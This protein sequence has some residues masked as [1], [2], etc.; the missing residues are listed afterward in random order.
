MK[1]VRYDYNM[2]VHT[3]YT[4][5]NTMDANISSQDFNKW[6]TKLWMKQGVFF[7]GML[8]SESGKRMNL[9]VETWNQIVWLEPVLINLVKVKS[10]Y[11]FHLYGH[12]E[13]GPLK[14]WSGKYGDFWVRS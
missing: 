6:P 4:H 2:G 12:W 13:C 1:N 3:C 11:I 7:T 5:N 9:K 14:A 10:S 8:A